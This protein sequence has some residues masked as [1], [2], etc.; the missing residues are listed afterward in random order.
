MSDELEGSEPS[1]RDTISN[2]VSDMKSDTPAPSPADTGAGESSS[3]SSSAASDRDDKGR[4]L[5]S[6]TKPAPKPRPVV[7][8]KP[9]LGAPA[10]KVDPRAPASGTDGQP[11]K[12][13]VQ[14]AKGPQSWALDARERWGELPAEVQREVLRVDKE[15]RQAFQ[16]TAQVRQEADGL[17]QRDQ[18]WGQLLSPHMQM[19]QAQG[20]NPMQVVQ[21]YLQ[22]GAVLHS[23][24]PGQKAALVADI[25]RNFGISVEGVAAALD[26]QPAPQ[27]QGYQQQPQIDPRAIAQQ[28]QQQVMQSFEQQRSHALNERTTR[29]VEDWRS[30]KEFLDVPGF[31]NFQ[32][33]LLTAAAE[34]G[35]PLD[36]DQAY[37][38]AKNGHPEVAAIMK[39][40]SEKESVANANASTQRA[41]AASTSIRSQPAG[42]TAQAPSESLHDDVRNAISRLRAQR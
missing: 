4:Y 16:Q 3:S 30:D 14:A 37:E 23:G 21:N 24:A 29:E 41:R 2:V 6:P 22:T 10:S 38:L 11:A 13:Q 36:L 8:T 27:G 33:A 32:A 42:I 34:A 31:V 19:I 35:Q 7:S 39:Q 40:R 25:I 20:G 1:L 17:R 28:V 26:G 12:G 18:A 15:V 9:T 5:S